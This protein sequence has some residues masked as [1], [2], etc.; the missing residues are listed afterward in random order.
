MEVEAVQLVAGLLRIHD[1]VID[2]EGSS[3]SVGGNAL[4]DLALGGSAPSSRI[5]AAYRGDIPDRSVLA[6]ELKELL[7]SDVVAVKICKR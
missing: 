3:L 7:R 5:E 1:V 6:E 2:N 4:A